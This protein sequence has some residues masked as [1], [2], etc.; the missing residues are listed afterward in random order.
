MFSSARLPVVSGCAAGARLSRFGVFQ[1][2]DRKGAG[3]SIG[4]PATSDQYKLGF[5]LGFE[6]LYAREGLLRLDAAFLDQLL[7]T[8]VGLHLQLTD[9]RG[10]SG[11]RTDKERSELIIAL[12]PYVED[13]LGEL[14][15]ITN[16][17]QALQARHNE[18]APFFAFKRKFIQKRA[19]SGVTKEQAEAIDGPGLARQLEAVFSEP[20]TERSF[21]AHVSRWLENEAGHT[22][23]IQTA[24]RYGAWAAL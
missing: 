9:A 4:M 20:P 19:I 18:F 2:R 11:A 15:G 24:S 23:L 13:F 16:Q 17:V 10:N 22:E 7:K 6:D 12:A 3:L 5:G 21:F 1:S 14:F 8:D